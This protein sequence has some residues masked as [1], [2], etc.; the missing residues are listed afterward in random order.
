MKKL[1]VVAFKTLLKA[2]FSTKYFIDTLLTKML[3]YLNGANFESLKSRGIPFLLVARGGILRAGQ[4]LVI[5]N[6][7]RS[8]PVGRGQ[9]CIFAVDRGAKIL[10]GDNVGISFATLNAQNSIVIHD[11]VLVGAGTCIYDSDFHPISP[12]LRRLNR[13][14][15]VKTSPVIIEENAFIGAACIILKGVTIGKNSVVG[16]Y[17]LV[18]KSI[19]PNQIWA[20]NPAQYIRN[21]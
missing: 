4:N 21:L 10:I 8:N 19:P 7:V 3:F 11:N 15:S 1:F 20:G 12:E 18:T 14:A 6:N 5:N 9:R 2:F 16:A 17:S 13:N